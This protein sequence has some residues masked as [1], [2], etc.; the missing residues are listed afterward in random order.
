ML[1]LAYIGQ[2][3]TA[4]AFF[5][6]AKGHPLTPINPSFYPNYQVLDPEQELVVAGVGTLNDNTGAYDATFT[7]PET[8]MLSTDTGSYSLL[9]N[10]VDTEKREFTFKELFDVVHPSYDITEAKEQ[11][12]LVLPMNSLY[13]S[14]PLPKRVMDVKLQIYDK[15]GGLLFDAIPEQAGL[16]SEYYIYT[17]EI[18]QG[19][20]ASGNDY[21][22]VWLMTDSGNTCVFTQV[23]HCASLWD[24]EKIS[25]LRMYLDKVAKAVDTYQGY[26]DS[27]LWF[28]IQQ[29]NEYINGVK[30]PTNWTMDMYQTNYLMAGM[31]YWLLEAAKWCALRAQYLA[32]GDSTFNF[33]GQPVSLDVDRSGYIE[34]ELGRVQGGLE[35]QLPNIKAQIY[36]NMKPVGHLNLSWPSIGYRYPYMFQITVAGIPLHRMPS[37][38]I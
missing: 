16:Y 3:V 36:K 38:R 7:I 20:F 2:E 13:M 1:R 18:P 29:G 14:L 8:A 9:W 6:D 35:N 26:K 5:S 34:S 27:E 37:I 15:N 19:T 11:Q 23:I 21:M 22:A 30:I 17:T 25:N 24:M 10:F 32:E 31:N 28:Y 4:N 12:K 33:S